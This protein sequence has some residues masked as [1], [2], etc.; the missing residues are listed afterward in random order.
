M[1]G[2]KSIVRSGVLLLL[3]LLLANNKLLAQLRLPSDFVKSL[4][5]MGLDFFQP[6]DGKYF[7]QTYLNNEL[8][9]ADFIIRSRK[10]K[11]EI[12]YNLFPDDPANEIDDLP[13]IRSIQMASHLAS[14]DDDSIVTA[15]SLSDDDL[16]KARFNA[17]WGKLFYFRPKIV[18]STREHCQMLV[19]YKEGKGMAFVFY[20]FDE[21]G[22]FLDNRLLSLAFYEE[23][24][25]SE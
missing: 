20:L 11:L 10:E 3:L 12:R 19:L 4:D 23:D 18:F 24:G 6:L 5:E 16:G 21:A 1:F 8:L 9:K 7:S 13:H 25:K 22:E 15:V 14:N 2:L 17:D